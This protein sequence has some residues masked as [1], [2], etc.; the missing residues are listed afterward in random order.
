MQENA[1]NY[2]DASDKDQ[3]TMKESKMGGITDLLLQ[4]IQTGT[5]PAGTWLNQS[6]LGQ[7]NGCKRPE[8]RQALD[9]LTPIAR[10]SAPY[11]PR[12]SGL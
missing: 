3:A 9:R 11:K 1:D 4:D 8:V 7:R 12:V 5:L 10:G 6:D 2:M